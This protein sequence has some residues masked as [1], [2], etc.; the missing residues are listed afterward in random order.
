M[1]AC[2]CVCVVCVREEALFEEQRVREAGK[3]S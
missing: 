3:A 1:Y 2:V